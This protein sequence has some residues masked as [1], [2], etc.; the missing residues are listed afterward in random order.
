MTESKLAGVVEQSPRLATSA[1][2]TVGDLDTEMV[3]GHALRVIAVDV[4]PQYA[5][6]SATWFR[7]I[8]SLDP[9]RGVL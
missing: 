9:C 3:H 8:P 7:P 5:A 1:P 6:T 4:P 2:R